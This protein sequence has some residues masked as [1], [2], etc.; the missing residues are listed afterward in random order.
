MENSNFS[1]RKPA[2]E[3]LMVT[4][5][6]FDV[7]Y[8][9]NPHMQNP[10]GTPKRV[11]RSLARAQWQKLKSTF[12]EVG[13]KVHMLEGQHGLPDMVFAANQCVTFR[14][15]QGRQRY[16]LSVMAAHARKPEVPFFGEWM[17]SH[18]YERL[19]LDL[20]SFHLE[21][22]GDLIW[23]EERQEF[24]AGHGFRTHTEAIDL[25][26][27]ASG[28]VCRKLELV[29]DLFYHLDTCLVVL[30]RGIGAYVP[31]AFD[32][33]SRREL[34]RGFRDLISADLNEAKLGFC[35][36]AYC[37]NGRDVILQKGSPRFVEELKRREFKVHEVDTGEF[38][39][40]G[41]SVFCLKL[42]LRGEPK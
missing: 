1:S 20:G 12:E 27:A 11:D 13:G 41:G 23:D 34:E 15:A 28:K 29:S 26:E 16:C 35:L 21:G 32:A 3:L 37:P 22:T 2:F 5:E 14:D 25:F 38:I 19:T 9:I 24:W 33:S 4:P 7:E 39:K 6:Y 30:G 17:E 36:N 18:A 31:E 10:D 42:E 8:V 40:A